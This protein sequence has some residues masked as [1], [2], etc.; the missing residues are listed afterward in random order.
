MLVNSM[1]PASNA[2]LGVPLN[3]L[4]CT[5]Y[6]KLIVFEHTAVRSWR[7]QQVTHGHPALF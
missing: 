5:A 6:N 4:N 3:A 1:L 7:T 2:Q